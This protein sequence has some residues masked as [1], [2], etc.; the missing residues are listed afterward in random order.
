MKKLIAIAGLSLLFAGCY[1][2]KYQTLYP[3]AVTQTNPCDTVKNPSTYTGNVKAIISANCAIS[4]C[5]DAAGASTS[6]YDM[7]GYAGVKQS[8]DDGTFVK[9]IV[10]TSPHS[11]HMPKGAAAQMSDCNLAQIIYWVNHGYQNN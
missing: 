6:I 8:I 4:G 3:P 7:S 10:W 11:N 2:D 1:N 5:H 9:D